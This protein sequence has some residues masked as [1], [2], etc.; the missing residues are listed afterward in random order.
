MGCDCDWEPGG[1]LYRDREC[2]EHGDAA[3]AARVAAREQAKDNC[4]TLCA[5]LD[6]PENMVN[7]TGSIVFFLRTF[8]P[9]HRQRLLAG[10]AIADSEGIWPLLR[11]P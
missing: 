6:L 11:E 2:P 9:D 4:K 5:A 7:V 1:F 10:L 3:V 8:P